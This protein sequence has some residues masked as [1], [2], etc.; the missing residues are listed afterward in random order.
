M[1]TD[2]VVAFIIGILG[3][4]VALFPGNL[5]AKGIVFKIGVIAVVLSSLFLIRKIIPTAIWQVIFHQRFQLDNICTQFQEESKGALEG[6]SLL[7]VVRKLAQEG[8]ATLYGTPPFSTKILRIPASHFEDHKILWLEGVI[9]IRTINPKTMWT[10]EGKQDGFFDLYAGFSLLG[11][12]RMQLLEM[13]RSRG[14]KPVEP[15][16]K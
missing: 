8:R 9:A 14:Q 5:E 15:D 6:E 2:A 3:L 7:E 13:K 10:D 4:F 11:L 1:S 12:L 16:S